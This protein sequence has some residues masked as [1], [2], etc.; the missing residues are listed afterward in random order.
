MIRLVVA[1]Q[2][3]GKAREFREILDTSSGRGTSGPGGG[4]EPSSSRSWQGP[5]RSPVQPMAA[6]GP[7]SPQAHTASSW[8][9]LSVR[10][11]ASRSG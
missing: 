2:N 10:R 11:R 8:S 3:Q 7:A 1:T 6:G 5:Q 9:P 4:P